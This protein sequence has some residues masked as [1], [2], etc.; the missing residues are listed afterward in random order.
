VRE[1][2][3]LNQENAR[4]RRR[5]GEKKSEREEDLKKKYEEGKEQ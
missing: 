4:E 3:N 2:E 1:G 5:V